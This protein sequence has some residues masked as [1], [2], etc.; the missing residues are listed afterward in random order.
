MVPAAALP[1]SLQWWLCVLSRA[2]DA[3]AALTPS[4]VQAGAADDTPAYKFLSAVRLG[5]RAVVEK[6][7]STG[8]QA[9][10]QAVDALRSLG[11]PL[12]SAPPLRAGSGNIAGFGPRPL[13]FYVPTPQVMESIGSQLKSGDAQSS[14][15]SC[16]ADSLLRVGALIAPRLFGPDSL[17]AAAELPF[18]E[19]LDSSWL[20]T[21]GDDSGCLYIPPSLALP[22]AAATAAST[23][24]GDS[25]RDG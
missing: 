23:M 6:F 18:P 19:R 5:V 16:E 12:Y 10:F 21:V 8:F 24:T 1:P 13:D 20:A 14:A 2:L 22:P 15:D 11:C 25:M 3:S 9:E 17:F 4:Q 7:N